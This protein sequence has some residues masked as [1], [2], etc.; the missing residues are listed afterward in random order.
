MNKESPK[1]QPG[2]TE[3]A[4]QVTTKLYQGDLAS[5][6]LGMRVLDTTPGCARVAMHVRSDM[7]NGHRVCHGGLIFALADSAFAYA[8]NSHGP[9]T[10]AAAASIDFLMPAREGDD[11]TASASELWRSGRSGLYEVEVTNQRGERIALFRGRSHQ[12]AGSNLEP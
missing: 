9:N 7:V 12:V 6:A 4:L 3:R 1:V 2:A 10:L 11:L 8:C 5:Q